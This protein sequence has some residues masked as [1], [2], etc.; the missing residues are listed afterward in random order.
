MRLH[1]KFEAGKSGVMVPRSDRGLTLFDRP[2]ILQT[3][4]GCLRQQG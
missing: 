2:S 3:L 1:S 4:Q